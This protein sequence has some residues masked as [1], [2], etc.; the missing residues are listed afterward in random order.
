VS[1]QRH[2]PAALCPGERTPVPIV[3]EAGWASEPVW[4]QRL[5]KKILCPCR[6]SNPD[7]PVV[8]SAVR[9]YTAWATL[10][11]YDGSMTNN[12]DMKV[13]MVGQCPVL[14]KFRNPCIKRWHVVLGG[15]MA[16]V[17]TTRPNVRKFNPGR[18]RLIF[19]GRYTM[20]STCSFSGEVK[21]EVP[22]LKI[23]RHVKNPSRYERRYF[24]RQNSTFLRHFFL[25]CY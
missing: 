3:Q 14:R 1:G 15:V 11:P 16:S 23:L 18:E 4:T 9:H 8:Q 5:K 20:R 6:G 17:L 12:V 25:L 2:A 24:I 21:P 10:A 19:I 7:R 22:L 13:R